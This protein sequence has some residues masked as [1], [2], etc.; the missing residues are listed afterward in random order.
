MDGTGATDSAQTQRPAQ[1]QASEHTPTPSPAPAQ[2][3]FAGAR[4]SRRGGTRRVTLRDV[5]REANVSLKT[6][7]NVIN[8][9]GR[10]APSTRRRVQTVI[11]R[12]GYRVNMTA[13]NLSRNSTGAIM[14]AV[15]SLIPPYLADLAN[16]TIDVARKHGYATYVTTY[17]E[18]TARGARHLLEQFNTSMADGLILS[19]GEIDDISPADLSVDFPLVVV[20]ARTTWGM[21]DHITPDD[22]HAA[23]TAAAYLYDHGATRLAVVGTRGTYDEQALLDADEGNAQLRLRGIIEESHRRGIDVDPRLLAPVQ[24]DWTIGA[25]S[26]AMQ[27]VID[28]GAP[29]D[30]VIGLNDQ[31]AIGALVALRADGIDVPGQAQVIGFDDTADGEFLQVPLTTMAPRLDWITATAVERLVARI[32]RA[33]TGAGANTGIHI[34]PE[35]FTCESY[36]IPRASTRA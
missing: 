6:A 5:A 9:S 22:V 36:V 29:F 23:A 28:A 34:A 35:R 26:R 27:D 15:P 16:R 33:G 32:E 7:S 31:L 20:G 18:G 11:E 3:E 4:I 21:A 2:H 24:L 30:G 10:M 12:L 25:G 13:R 17:A 14:L 1:T 19:L 8:Q